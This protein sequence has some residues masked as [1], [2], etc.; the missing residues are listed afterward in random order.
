MKIFCS[1]FW[2]CFTKK[3]WIGFLFKWSR[4]LNDLTIMATFQ[5]RKRLHLIVPLTCTSCHCAPVNLFSEVS[6]TSPLDPTY[7]YL[8]RIIKK[9]RQLTFD[10][11]TGY[12][13]WRTVSKC[14]FAHMY[15]RSLKES[16]VHHSNVSNLRSQESNL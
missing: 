7:V 1:H 6:T 5:Q 2:M 15:W 13:L 10:L 11:T 3:K 16:M 4:R 14:F 8:N 9:T 12:Y